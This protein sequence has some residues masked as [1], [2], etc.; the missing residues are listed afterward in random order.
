MNNTALGSSTRVFVDQRWW[1]RA[2]A[3]LVW[4][5]VSDSSTV[6]KISAIRGV[7]PREK[8][9]RG[10]HHPTQA[11]WFR[12]RIALAGNRACDLL[13]FGWEV[14]EGRR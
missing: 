7:F 6:L 10:L 12:V 11:G 9:L 13:T 4:H 5:L 8:L 3:G 1:P 2:S 14:W